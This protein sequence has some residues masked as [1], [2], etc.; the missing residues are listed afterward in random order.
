[1][2]TGEK[3]KQARKNAGLTQKELGEKL[4]VSQA[5]V[6]QFENENSNPK[7]KTIRKIAEALGVT[8][9]ELVDDWKNFSRAEI[10]EDISEENNKFFWTPY[11]DDKLKQLGCSIG[12]DE[13]ETFLWINYPD[14]ILEVT[15]ENLKELDK[16]TM[17]Y[18]QFKL[19]ELKREHIK[20]FRPK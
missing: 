9:S 15:E 6:G 19:E 20:N 7:L 2:S 18:L 12:Y 4:G 1:M 13:D 10:I 5:A 11:L 3:I 8:L 16:S 14:G 17:S